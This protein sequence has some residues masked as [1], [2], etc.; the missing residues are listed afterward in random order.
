MRQVPQLSKYLII[1]NGRMAR[2]WAHYFKLSNIPFSS[3]NR[4]DNSTADLIQ[5]LKNHPYCLLCINDDQIK[6]FHSQFKNNGHKFIHFSG[7]L[8][9]EDILG[10]HPLM[11]FSHQLY[12]IEIYQSIYIVGSC[13][14]DIFRDIFPDL[15][16]KYA[17]VFSV[18]KALYH[19]L[20][21]LAGN[22]TT[23]L[24]DLISQECEKLKLPQ[25]AF[26]PYLKQVTENILTQQQGRWTGP[27]YRKD[28]DTIEQNKKALEEGPLYNLYLE[29]ETLS[30]HSGMKNE[31]HPRV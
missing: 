7:S 26:Q 9:D 15:K 19:S 1:G 30:Q 18:E 17:K 12:D 4:N 6:D 20:C 16:N 5:K 29:L 3:W 11:T 21:V 23:L 22:G 10:F 24:W 8:V 25:E 28:K 2:H 27:W 14:E 31:K 13:D